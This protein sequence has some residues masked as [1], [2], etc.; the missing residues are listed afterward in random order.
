M[1][2]IYERNDVYVVR[3]L[4]SLCVNVRCRFEVKFKKYLMAITLEVQL[5]YF[6]ALLIS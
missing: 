1:A 6:L 5:T 2:I 3:K 4:N